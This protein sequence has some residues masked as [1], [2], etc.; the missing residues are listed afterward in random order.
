VPEGDTI[1]R[2]ANRLRPALVGQSLIRFDVPRAVGKRPRP[3]TTIEA[4]EA[5]GKHL[6]IRFGGGITL[7]THM[8]M[9]GSWHLYRTGERWK[10]PAH[11]ARAVIDVEG[12]TAVCFSAPVVELESGLAA[13]A[14]IAHLGPDLTSL[15]VTDDDVE[16]AVDRMTDAEIGVVL[17]DQ[18]VASGIGNIWKNETLFVCG[19]DPFRSAADVDRDTKRALIATASKLLR[20]SM[21]GAARPSNVY[22]R[23]GRPCRRCGTPIRAQRQGEQARTTYW[24]PTCQR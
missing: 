14:S 21:R 13:N 23:A 7:R 9:T 3:G 16:R 6:L 12:W 24:C 2:T 18:R 20:A 11:L 19:V 15:D 17:L 10:K 8:R 4:V 5:V 1:H 22:G